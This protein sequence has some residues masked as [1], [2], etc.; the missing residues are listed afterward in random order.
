M[1]ISTHTLFE[2]G[3]TQLG[4]LQSGMVKTQQQIATGRRIL[5]PSDDPVGA[6]RALEVAQTQSLNTQYEVNRQHAKSALGTLEGTLSSVTALLQDVK[7]TVIAAGNGTLGDTERGFMAAELNGRLEALLGLANTRDAA[8]NYVFSGFQT[9]MPAYSKDAM[10]G[11]V[12][13]DGDVGQR[14]IQVDATR[15]MSV[16]APG[17]TVFQGT[18]WD[19]FQTLNDLV[20][21]LNTPGT[22]GLAAGL[23]T[24]NSDLDLALDS[25]LTVR[26]STGSRLQ[27]LD[28]LDYAGEDR[29]L[30]YSQILSE[31]QDLDYTK[32]ITQLSQQQMTLE[33][34]Q[35]SFVKASGLSLF[36]FI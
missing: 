12:S 21:L 18:G 23:A 4:D 7:T 15:Q 25:V 6:A 36:N 28:A 14:L 30:Q 29:N 5:T 35:K 11:V 16:T 22:A 19:M 13:Y 33:A 2:S 26:A 3:A 9:T 17:S 32:A 20:T 1:R 24:A 31:L 8:G 27:E 10:T 34:A